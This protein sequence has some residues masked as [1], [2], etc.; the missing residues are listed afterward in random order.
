MN[1]SND[2]MNRLC[3][4]CHKPEKSWESKKPE[5]VLSRTL[6]SELIIKNVCS[7][8]NNILSKYDRALCQ[9]LKLERIKHQ[10]PQKN[11]RKLKLSGYVSSTNYLDIHLP[12]T[13]H[14]NKTSKSFESRPIGNQYIRKGKR[15][16]FENKK[17]RRHI[18]DMIFMPRTESKLVP[19]SEQMKYKPEVKITV[20]GLWP[21]NKK[22]EK[23]ILKIAYEFL[24]IIFGPKLELLHNCKCTVVGR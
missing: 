18:D 2:G 4:F 6:G 21:Y 12:S 5:H 11:N 9:F 20:E 24:F 23:G 14:W 22:T 17:E 10:I 16:T 15:I 13:F 7:K 8:C 19:L 3:I 1:N